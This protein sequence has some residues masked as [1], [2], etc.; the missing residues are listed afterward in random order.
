MFKHPDT[1]ATFPNKTDGKPEK[2]R[3][4]TRCGAC[5]TH[6]KFLEKYGPPGD[7]SES[8]ARN[9]EPLHSLAFECSLCGLCS[10]ICPHGINPC[11]MFHQW[12]KDAVSSGNLE[13]S[14]YKTI[15]RY[16]KI[17]SSKPF[18]FYSLPKNC[19]T[20]F[21]PGCTLAG[22]R[23]G[24]TLSA[25]EYLKS[26]KP[27]TG[28]VLDCCTKP[29]H[30]LGRMDFF[31]TMFNQMIRFLENNGVETVITACPSCHNVFKTHSG[32]KA[33]SIYQVMAADRD[34]SPQN[35]G[36]ISKSQNTTILVQDPC[37]ARYDTVTQDAVRVLARRYG[38]DD[39]PSQSSRTRTLCCGEGASAGCV[40]PGMALAWKNKRVQSASGHTALTYCAGCVNKLSGS[41]SSFHVLDL[42]FGK[43]NPLSGKAD[44]SRAPLTYINRLKLKQT[45]KRDKAH[46]TWQRPF[47]N[48]NGTDRF[49]KNILKIGSVVAA[50]FAFQGLFR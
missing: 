46:T 18:S 3:Q 14:P 37:Q 32:L 17:G 24:I 41:S 40:N 16:E 1:A 47:Y 31:S 8:Y 15:L 7:L 10:A 22:T 43:S 48:G 5:M 23:P 12:R 25:F 33:E 29:S 9:P 39:K 36:E 21:F 13:L 49:F 11:A 50:L 42:I 19:N 20:V 34:F 38:L 44:I 28:I 35:C 4:C 45:I 30:D 6:C 2:R 26:V 27:E